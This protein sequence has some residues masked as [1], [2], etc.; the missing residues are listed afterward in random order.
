MALSDVFKVTDKQRLP[1]GEPLENVYFYEQIGAAGNASDLLAAFVGDV[2]PL[3][4]GVQSNQL[5]HNLIKV[6]NIGDVGDFDEYGAAGQIGAV[7]LAIRNEWDCYPFTLR[8]SSRAVRPGSKRI[9]G[10][11]ES[12]ASYTAGVVVDA[13]LLT[14]LHALR[15]QM[16]AILEGALES[17]QP[18]IL[19]RV[20]DG[21]T[22]RLPI[23]DG[24][25]VAVAVS[26]VLLN[27]KIGHQVSRGNA[28]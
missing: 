20:L 28:R 9:G 26:T 22:Y 8:P 10:V 7:G 16:G 5:V 4:K 12:D 19:K 15:A 18:I 24:E 14:A 23:T 13:T 27:T 2:L 21:G 25:T 11:Y 1:S 17:Y 3:L 6:E